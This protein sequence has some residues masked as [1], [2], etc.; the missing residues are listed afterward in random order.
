MNDQRQK[1]GVGEMVYGV[2]K[3]RTAEEIEDCLTIGSPRT[4]PRLTEVPTG[5]PK[6]WLFARVLLF[7]GL[8]YLGFTLGYLKYRNDALMPGLILMGTFAGPLTTLTLFFELNLPKN[9]SIYRLA[10]LMC[11]GGLF[12]LLLSLVG[13]DIHG[14]DRFSPCSAGIIE[15]SAKL[16]ALALIVRSQRYP[17]ILN[18]MLLGAAVGAG[19]GAFES[20]GM[21]LGTLTQNGASPML[22][23]IALRGMLTPLMHVA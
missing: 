13:Y 1:F 9:V 6:P 5:F 17:Y 12:S 22:I 3:R 2:F 19:F 7:F 23:S 4:T 10:V 16:G 15:E 8:L 14:L 21:A 18:G 11:V 20:A